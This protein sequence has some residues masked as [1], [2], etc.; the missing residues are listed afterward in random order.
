MDPRNK[1]FF[2]F[3]RNLGF[4][5]R[6]GPTLREPPPLLV[7]LLFA[8]ARENCHPDSSRALLVMSSAERKVPPNGKGVTK[9]SIAVGLNRGLKLNRRPKAHRPS[10][11]KGVRN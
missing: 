11:R 1:E 5:E 6:E 4:S 3:G 8:Q 9:S 7:F 10:S 2:R